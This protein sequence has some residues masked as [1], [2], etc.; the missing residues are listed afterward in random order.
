[1]KRYLYKYTFLSLLLSLSTAYLP[2]LPEQAW[3][4]TIPAT[5]TQQRVEISSDL[6]QRGR[7][8]YEAGQFSE[9][10]TTWQ[11]AIQTYQAQGETLNQATV[12]ANLSLAYQQ[13]GQWQPAETAIA[14]SLDL[15]EQ[16]I[17]SNQQSA[18]IAQILDT[19]GSWQFGRG[20]HEA[21]IATWQ[22]AMRIHERL[23][24]DFS[25][26]RNLLNQVQALKALGFYRRALKTSDTANQVLQTQP[27]SLTKANGLLSLGD[28]LQ[29]VGNLKEAR[30]AL[31]Q[32]LAIA[33]KAQS[34][35]DLSA[36]QLSLGNLAYAEE[37]LSSALSYYT[38][39][40]TSATSPITKLQ[41]QLN[42]FSLLIQSQQLTSLPALQEQLQNQ[43]A[44]LPLSRDAV[45][46]RINF[47]KSLMKLAKIH[48]T[49]SHLTP[50]LTAAI[51]ATA[52][53]QAKFLGDR[54]VTSQALGTLGELYE[55][56]GQIKEALALT[57]QALAISQSL[58]ATDISYRWQWQ[59]GRLLKKQGDVQGAIVVYSEAVNT[60]DK[61]RGDLVAVNPSS[62]FSFRE[63]VEPVYRQLVSLL[64]QDSDQNKQKNLEKAQEV[65]ESLQLAELVNFFRADCLTVNP[66][67]IAKI[68][69]NAAVLYPIILDD[70]LEVVISLPQQPLRHYTTQISRDQVERIL[71]RMRSDLVDH[72]SNDYLPASQQ[73][74]DWLIRPA[75]ADLAKSNVK[76]L[77]FVLDGALRNIPMSVLYDGEHYLVEN[78]SIALTP[79]LNLLD[80]RP[81]SQQQ[82]GAITGGLSES[83]QGFSSLPHVESELKEIQAQVPNQALLNQSF[84]NSN[85]QQTINS[86]AFPVIHL[87]T[88]GQFSSKAEETFLLT[89]DGRVNI[90]QLNQF[91]QRRSQDAAKIV[92]LLVLSAC[93]TAVGD[94]R[95]ALGL[96]GVAVRAGAR[97][98]IASLWF[99]SDEG[100][101][102][103][104][105]SLYRDLANAQITR[106]EAL[107]QS[108]LVLLQNRQ[109]KH[110]YYWAPFVLLGN[111]L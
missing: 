107:R 60:L 80:P 9:A 50:Q 44:Q 6:V 49:P 5:L 20:E 84:T 2:V 102:L 33:Q 65:I 51:L 54:R 70:R 47:A 106:A 25:R 46:A 23:G 98:T 19:K 15:A 93:Q 41:A 55:Q 110:P 3:S 78:Y 85:L 69:P 64:L 76:T 52:V 14:T 79:G 68:D 62:Q 108:Q 53:Q 1:M 86:V 99:I 36:I 43:F 45:F 48:P 94:K 30:Q 105:T 74:Y 27:D 26:V 92:E 59:L 75:A 57:Q 28:T 11:Q 12:L 40:A 77:V 34:A 31:V 91:L 24:D 42:Q 67:K 21:A 88:H 97:S 82:I 95:A 89:Y 37:N 58:D 111:W 32:S 100:T 66:V 35:T 103:L 71:E 18:V 29:S 56:T 109:Y 13:L 73:V 38:Q 72:T 8:F 61:L 83:R 7:Q 87:A 16:S 63:S 39:A 81:I 90:D 10:V 17:V 96:A 101:S 4:L 22:E 104:M